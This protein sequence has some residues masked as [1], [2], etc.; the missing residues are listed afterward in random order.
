MQDLLTL[1]IAMVVVVPISKQLGL[2]SVIGYLIAG[3]IIGPHGFALLTNSVEDT[4][5]LAELGVTMMLLLI[6]LELSP[7]L[8][9]KLRGP[10]FGLGSIQVFS[11]IFVFSGIGLFFNS[12]WITSLTVGMII[13]ISS[14]AIALQT[15]QELGYMKS[16]GGERALA[17]LLFQDM[18]VIPM[19]AILPFLKADSF[20][21]LEFSPGR[22]ALL[23]FAAVGA[24]VAVGRFL[25]RPLFK[26]VSRTK[27]NETFTALALLIVVAAAG[28]MHAVDLSPALGAFLAGVVLADSE[29]KHQ[30]EADIAPFKGLLLGLFF[31]TI[32]S[33][34]QIGLLVEKPM[35]IAQ[36]ILGIVGIKAI[37]AYG[38]GRFSKMRPPESL[39]FAISLA[40]GGEFAFVVLAQAGN[41]I[42]ESLAQTLTLSIVLSMAVAPLLMKWVVQ[43]AM[44]RLD[45]VK[46]ERRQPDQIDQSE[47][48]NPV[49]VIGIGRFGQTL[50]R[51]LRANGYASTVLDIDSEQ[52]DIMARFG[53]KS[54]FG[55]G[56]NVDLLRAAGL[57]HAKA[58]VIAI[59]EPETT[60]KIT[61]TIRQQYPNLPI[62]AR[63]YDRVHAY[64]MIHLGI[65]ELAIETSGSAL[66]LGTEVLKKLG[67]QPDQA[68]AMA[69]FFQVNNQKSIYD[70]AKR[71]LEDDRETFFKLSKQSSEQLEAMLRSD[72]DEPTIPVD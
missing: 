62:F 58:L 14:T 26:L 53:I 43:K 30:I 47:K 72:P 67:M 31:I 17:V 57:D 15:L 20:G 1:L 59:D 49:L 52:I 18:A 40:G 42:A 71:F 48:D 34:I 44:S 6:G 32:G 54:Y 29:F 41:L 61:E 69:R 25:M 2:G 3:A 27:S 64:R 60:T 10:I 5:K 55:D 56:S 9:W 35:V 12:T 23:V 46:T 22:K 66:T 39:L 21:L 68:E 13:S 70:L 45:C 51:F 37:L 50:V 19:L 4:S 33:S 8:L 28:L 63:V 65:T 7:K 24:V 36:W 16:T 11:A 38:I